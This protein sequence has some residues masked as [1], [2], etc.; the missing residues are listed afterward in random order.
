MLCKLKINLVKKKQLTSFRLVC[1]LSTGLKM[2]GDG[3]IT[4]FF[5]RYVWLNEWPTINYNF[6]MII[7]NIYKYNFHNIYKYNFLFLR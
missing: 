7:N 2:T 5:S 3:A 1:F 6:D 4:N